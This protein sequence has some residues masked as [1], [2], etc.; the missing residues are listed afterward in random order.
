MGK[1]KDARRSL[2]HGEL[3]A[4]E[5]KRGEPKGGTDKAQYQLRAQNRAEVGADGEFH[6]DGNQ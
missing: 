4:S 3:P 1:V 6:K 2:R 5:L